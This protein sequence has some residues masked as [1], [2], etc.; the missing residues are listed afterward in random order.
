MTGILLRNDDL[1]AIEEGSAADSWLLFVHQQLGIQLR[2][3]E[4]DSTD[5]V[6][7]KLRLVDQIVETFANRKWRGEKTLLDAVL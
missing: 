1:D 7:D 4:A 2:G 3:K 6:S 5:T